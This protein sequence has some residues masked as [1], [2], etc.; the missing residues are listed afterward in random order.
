MVFVIDYLV[1]TLSTKGSTDIQLT[2]SERGIII[3]TCYSDLPLDSIVWWYNNIPNFCNFNSTCEADSPFVNSTHNTSGNGT[4]H[5]LILPV[6]RTL[7]PGVY[8]C[9]IYPVPGH[10]AVQQQNFTIFYGKS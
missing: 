5:Q 6:D 8:S 2:Y 1:P 9:G 10:T 7:Q 3:M 4:V